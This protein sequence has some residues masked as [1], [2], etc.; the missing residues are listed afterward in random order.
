MRKFLGL[1]ALVVAAALV[2]APVYAEV[3][4]VKVSG[5]V[6]VK[7]ITHH[8]F[9]LKQKQGNLGIPPR[10]QGVVSNDDEGDI[11]LQT[12][13]VRVDADLTDNVSAAVRLLNQRIW[14]GQNDGD[15]NEIVLDNAY[16]TL[17]ELVY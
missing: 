16:V 6:N 2:A 11:I 12:T 1:V 10:Q 4:N 8:D 7:A 14:D 13:R 9:D 15:G 5:D 3:Q 17:K